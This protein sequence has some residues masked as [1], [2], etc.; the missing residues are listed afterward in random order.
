MRSKEQ[1]HDYRYFPDPD[2]LPV[3]VDPE[4][5][6]RIKSELPELPSQ[7]KDRFIKK[8]GIPPY[9]AGVLTASRAMA[10]YFED[11]VSRFPSPKMVSNWIMTELIE[12]TQR[13]RVPHKQLPGLAQPDGRPAQID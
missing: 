1:A 9:D 5:V 10:A 7:K 3:H 6:E 13:R 12:R 8:F 11:T 2:L 4:L